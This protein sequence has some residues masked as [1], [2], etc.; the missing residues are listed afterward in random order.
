MWLAILYTV[1]TQS[2]SLKVFYY[3]F[4]QFWAQLFIESCH[5]LDFSTL[6]L[7]FSQMNQPINGTSKQNKMWFVIL[8]RQA[9]HV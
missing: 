3:G 1:C 2:I 8:V 5:L 7:D 9:L 4:E 6:R